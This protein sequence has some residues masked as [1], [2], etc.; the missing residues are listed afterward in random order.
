MRAIDIG[1]GTGELTRHLHDTLGARET[2]GYDSSNTMLAKS[3]SFASEGLS[4]QRADMDALELAPASKDLVF[5][6]AA[7]HWS[8]D[9]PRL[10]ARVTG[11]IAPEGQLAVQVPASFDR[12]EHTVAHDLAREAPFAQSL[13][14]APLAGALAPEA[15]ASLLYALGYREQQ[16]RLQVYP[17]VLESKDDVYEWARGTVLTPYKS[18]LEPELYARFE[19]EYQTR[20]LARLPNERPFFFPFKRILVWARRS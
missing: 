9:Q 10:F 8:A 11:A 7:F 19:T 15:Y 2:V 16:V 3:A 14:G 6:N 12:P 4:F 18:R 20:L 17:H 1:C 5:S 13:T